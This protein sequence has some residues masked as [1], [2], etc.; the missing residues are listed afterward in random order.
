MMKAIDKEYQ[1]SI[2]PERALEILKEGN[3]RFMNNLK[4]NR[5]LL[6]QA[7]Q[8]RNG[9]WPFATILSCID[10]R[11]SAELIFD[12]GLGD[13]FSIR[14]AGNIVNTDII[15]SM[16]FACKLAG[17]KLLVVLGHTRCGAVKGA[18][19]HVEMGNLTELLAK[20]QTAVYLE[21]ETLDESQRNSSNAVFVENVA[22]ISVKRSVQAIIERSYILEQMIEKGKIAIIGAMHDLDTGMVEFYEDTL[23]THSNIESTRRQDD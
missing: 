4:A 6:Q 5:D 14:I 1:S 19:D 22:T 23:I 10:S 12:Q 7:N 20:L 15:G 8:T 3:E 17:S 2:T 21:K 13:I 16:E 11:T 18:C 9:Q